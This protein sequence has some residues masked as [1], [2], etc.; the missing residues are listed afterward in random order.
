MIK[1]DNI[2]YARNINVIGGVETYVYELA[3]KYQDYDIAV[4]CKTIAPE[5]R[6]RLEKLCRVYIHTNEQIEC[7]VIITNWDTSIINYVNE[8]AKVYTGIHTDYSHFSQGCLPIDN[9]RITYI[10]ITQDSKEK[11]EKI[12]GIKRTIL[13]RNPLSIEKEEKPL[14]LMSATRLTNE[15]GGKRMLALANELDKQGINYIWFLFTS[16]EYENNPV[17][18]NP[19]VIHMNNRLDL[20]YFYSLASWYVQF[21]EV[22][23]DSYSLKEALYRGIPIAVCELP[24]FKEIGIEDG[25]NA[26][27]LNLD[28]SNVEEVAKK[29]REPLKFT[30]EPVK[31]D[32]DKIIVAGKSIYKEELKMKAKVKCIKN[33]YDMK[34]N[35]N[36]TTLNDPFIVDLIRAEELVA[37]GVCE[38][39]ERLEEPKVEDAAVKENNEVVADNSNKSTKVKKNKKK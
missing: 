24:Y 18:K 37:A 11:F 25:K 32:Y 30:F 28:C 34:F 16:D 1:H 20:D 17:W 39:V 13:C 19:N 26:L 14:I 22:E 6:K 12:S 7:K 5:Q 27:Y 23:G 29:I 9:E 35:K 4:V 15:K 38:I 21:S 10:G 8:D 36:I 3:K 2:I 31:D 33:Y